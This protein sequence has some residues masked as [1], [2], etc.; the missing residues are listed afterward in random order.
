MKHP[1][2]IL[3]SAL[4]LAA[5][6]AHAQQLE[7]CAYSNVPVG[8]NF[9]IAGYTYSSGGL[10]TDPSLPLENAQLEISTLTMGFGDAEKKAA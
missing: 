10:A 6:L 2:R 8:L 4:A 7:P 5:P 9:L 1:A 3:G